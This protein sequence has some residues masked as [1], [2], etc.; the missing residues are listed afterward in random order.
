MAGKLRFRCRLRGQQAAPCARDRLPLGVF[1]ASES[2]VRLT[3]VNGWPSRGGTFRIRSGIATRQNVAADASGVADERDRR[4]GEPGA[5]DRRARRPRRLRRR[6]RARPAPRDAHL[7]RAADRRATRTRSRSRSTSGSSTSRRSRSGSC[8]CE[9]ELRLNRRLAPAI[10]LDVVAITGSVDRAGASA[11]TG[12]SIEY[13]VKM[14]EF[15]Q[16]ALAS[17]ML[18]RGALGA[19]HVDA[20]AR[21]GRRVPRPRR[22]RAAPATPFG[23]PDDDPAR[24]RCRTSTQIRPLRDDAARSR[25]AGRAARTGREREH[26]RGS[27]AI[28]RG[29]GAD[30][31]VRECHGDL[32]LGNIARRRRRGHRSSTASSSTTSCAG[33]T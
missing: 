30:G 18:A 8:Y 12:R 19:A 7:A 11:A 3:H 17:R 10:Y 28:R 6:L 16:E 1:H 33:S 26:A 14:R 31:F 32:H 15:P 4:P 20:L 2:A 22:R 13:A 23:T 21:G 27:R 25:A 29:A 24:S 5:A 9:Q